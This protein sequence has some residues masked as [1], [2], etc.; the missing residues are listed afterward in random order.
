MRQQIPLADGDDLQITGI[1]LSEPPEV[2][3]LYSVLFSLYGSTGFNEGIT[4]FFP[5]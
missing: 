1:S 4:M 3:I 5:R 2:H